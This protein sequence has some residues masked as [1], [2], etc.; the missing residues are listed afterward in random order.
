MDGH[1]GGLSIA[2]LD[3][4]SPL[5]KSAASGIASLAHV[6]QVIQAFREGLAVGSRNMRLTF[7]NFHSRDDSFGSEKLDK[8]LP[9]LR[10]MHGRFL[11]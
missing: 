5:G 10:L 3:D 4:R 11:E 1:V 6:G 2:H 8:I 9:I 7:I